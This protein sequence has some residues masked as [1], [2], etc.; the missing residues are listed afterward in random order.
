MKERR[1]FDVENDMGMMV[2][3]IKGGIEAVSYSGT[4][5]QSFSDSAY[6]TPVSQNHNLGNHNLGNQQFT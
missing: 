2:C 5:N 1:Y 4:A 6:G 3:V